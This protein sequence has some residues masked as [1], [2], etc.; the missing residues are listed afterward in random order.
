MPARQ[1]FYQRWLLIYSLEVTAGLVVGEIAGRVAIRLFADIP[2]VWMIAFMASPIMTG[3][4]VGVTQW[5]TL[6]GKKIR[7]DR[8]LVVSSLGW[9]AGNAVTKLVSNAIFGTVNLALFMKI[10][11]AVVWVASGIVGGAIGGA[12]GGASFGLIQWLVLR[13]KIPKAG[14]WILVNSLGWAASNAVVGS[15][16]LAAIGMM[17]LVLIWII[18]GTIYGVI[19]GRAL[20]QFVQGFNL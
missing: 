3:T 6:K 19:T 17:G 4:L 5:F 13:G 1:K 2:G 7:A 16:D 12:I 9:A 8:W 18:Y 14:K 11:L 15:F 20:L 10:D